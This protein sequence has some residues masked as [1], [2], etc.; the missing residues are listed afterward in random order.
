MDMK[1]EP[2]Y[3]KEGD[4]IEPGIDV[5]GVPKQKVKLYAKN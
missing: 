5:L 1:P 2:V 3:L 4:L